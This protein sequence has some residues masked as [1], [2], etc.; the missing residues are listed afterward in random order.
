MVTELNQ[1]IKEA[2][3]VHKQSEESEFELSN[4]FLTLLRKNV[5]EELTVTA[6]VISCKATIKT[7]DNE[8]YRFLVEETQTNQ[9]F[10]VKLASSCLQVPCVG[11]I[12]HIQVF[13][14]KSA[15]IMAI[16]ESNQVGDVVVLKLPD[17]TVFKAQGVIFDTKKFQLSSQHFFVNSTTTS[18][19]SVAYQQTGVTLTIDANRIKQ[20][21]QTT[22]MV[23]EQS[24]TKVVNA[25]RIVAGT[26]R[27]KALNINYSAEAVA[28][29]SGSV[30]MLNGRE[31][32]KSDGKLMVVG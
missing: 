28:K 14:D 30:T 24:T 7:Q 16:L 15:Y 10:Y 1:Q 29:L 32:L 11:D 9:T 3:N 26:D 12:V 18:I 13:S 21:A 17:N 5:S 19:N 22:E 6:A 23:A 31:L 25:E 4:D 8:S 27:V 20:S 2:E